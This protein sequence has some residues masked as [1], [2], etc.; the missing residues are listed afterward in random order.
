[1]RQ[2]KQNETTAEIPVVIVSADGTSGQVERL[3]S[4]GAHTY[5]TKPLDVKNFVQLFEELLGQKEF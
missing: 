3:V 1:M 5:L 4:L 2:L